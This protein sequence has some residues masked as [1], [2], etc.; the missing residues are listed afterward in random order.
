MIAPELEPFAVDVDS[1]TELP[2]NPRRGDV[3]AVKRS[4][5]AF[6]QQKPIK[7]QRRGSEIVVIDGNHQLREIGRASCRERV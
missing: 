5:A 7:V 3:E 6:G 1:L 4:Y 2:G